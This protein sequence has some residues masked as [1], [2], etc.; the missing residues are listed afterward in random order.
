MSAQDPGQSRFLDAINTSEAIH[1]AFLI[2]WSLQELKSRVLLKALG[3]QSPAPASVSTNETRLTTGSP[4]TTKPL[5]AFNLGQTLLEGLLPSVSP[6]TS[7]TQGMQSDLNESISRTSQWQAIFMRIASV[8]EQCFPA[9]TTAN[10]L[11]D[12]SPTSSPSERFPYL[13][14]SSTSPTFPDYALIGTGG[15]GSVGVGDIDEQLGK[16]QLYDVT[17]RALN[18]LCLLYTKPQE[19]LLPDIIHDYQSQIIQSIFRHAQAAIS[20]KPAGSQEVLDQKAIAALQ[21][22]LE[23]QVAEVVQDFMDNAFAGPSPDD[24]NAAI[25]F[26]S[27]L[28]IRFLESWDGYLRENF[29]VGGQLKN[30]ELELLAYEAGRSL[31]TVSW[32]I[33][34]ATVPIESAPEQD[35]DSAQLLAQTWLDVLESSHINTVQRQISALG[36]ALDDAYYVIKQVQPSAP[37]ELPDPDLPGN[38][39]HAITYSLYYWQRA[40]K[41][42][43]DN[44]PGGTTMSTTTAQ[45]AMKTTTENAVANTPPMDTTVSTT[46][47]EAA[48][49]ITTASATV[50]TSP[51]NGTQKTPALAV[52]L[53][54]KL[55]QALITQSGIWQ[56]LMLGQQTL[57][58]FSTGR[59]TQRILNNI[60]TEFENAA[61]KQVVSTTQ[62]ELKRFWLPMIGLGIFLLVIL[63]GGIYLLAR[64]GQLQSLAA[65]IAILFG[66]AL[67]LVSTFLTRISSTLSPAPGQRPPPTNAAANNTNLEQRLGSLVGLAG[68]AIVTGFQ[69]AYK[70]ILVEFDDLNHNVAVSYPLIDVFMLLSSKINMEIKDSYV[71][72]TEVVWTREEQ[73]EEVERVAR[74]AFGPLGALIGSSSNTSPSS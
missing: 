45:V 72:L 68:E 1:D 27:F 6:A 43:C 12:P 51:S 53:S 59:V 34:L 19:S 31:S 55:R 3:L 69:N 5:P 22:N 36:P 44:A 58:S 61:K 9:S 52:D 39:I 74:A 50:S 71:F 7:Q 29:F 18:C 57:R 40:L 35:T 17:R 11:Y 48:I 16:F 56:T 70:Q 21:D 67:T 4:V 20:V 32:G 66:S 46:T 42:I 30:N 28:T 49:K 14:P 41:W 10:T 15:S 62:N 23:Q 73:K 8:H 60:M 37:G 25:K 13:Y 38:A 63:A 54:Q 24:L 26:L 64:S 47:T 33:S 2:G 65:L